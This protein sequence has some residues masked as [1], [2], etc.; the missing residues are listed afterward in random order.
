MTM[1]RLRSV[2]LFA[3]AGA[4]SCGGTEGGQHPGLVSVAVYPVKGDTQT[5]PQVDPFDVTKA[6]WV[7]VS[8]TGPL[9]T[10]V[11]A[12]ER[13]SK[14]ELATPGTIP[15]GYARQVTVEVCSMDCEPSPTCDP[16]DPGVAEAIV[17]RGRSVPFDVLEPGQAPEEV[18][19]FV[20]PRNSFAKPARVVPGTKATEPTTPTVGDRIG[21]TATLLDDGRVLILGGA[22][23]KAGA[24][25][26]FRAEDLEA[27]HG[28]AEVY[29]PK[30][31]EF[32][33]VGAMTRPR[34]FH[35]AVKMSNGQVAVLGG[36]T[37]DSGG[38]PRLDWTVEFFDP[39]TGT[40]GESTAPIAPWPDHNT[41]V[42]GGRALFTAALLDASTNM[43][44]IAG[45]IA[46][47]GVAGGFADVYWPDHGI[48]GHVPL[49]KVRYNHAMVFVPDYGRGVL[50]DDRKG[51]PTFVLFGGQNDSGTVAEVEPLMVSGYQ[52]TLDNTAVVN[53]PGGGR[54]LLSAVHVPAQ[55]ITYVIGGFTD[56]TLNSPSNRVDVYRTNERGFR[57]NEQGQPKEVLWLKEA[58]GAMTATL[59][60]FNTILIAGGRG[61][62][63]NGMNTMELIVENRVCTDPVRQLGCVDMINVVHGATPLLEPA[64]AA[65][66]ALFD[67]TRRVFFVG[68]FS[69]PYTPVQD[70]VFY[71]PD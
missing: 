6:K 24:V 8:V 54:T 16:C 34:A 44:L 4:V 55:Q 15:F 68:G 5:S 32:R 9:M 56:L 18:A 67:A 41:G 13:F 69:Q 29:D 37:Q 43:I 31:G 57:L 51:V 17:A 46:D 42:K 10:P 22:K 38:A 23:V 20:T 66:L 50:G 39:K 30:T 3:L 45:G 61:G 27:V 60:D 58:R 49:K 1:H 40:F 36:Y 53:L 65:H 21:A 35:Q 25:T 14:Y 62:G 64:R 70:A 19:V 7:K 11:V 71:N 33:E 26:W 12:T 47:P 48:V 28:K 63:G 52:V 59:M 2:V